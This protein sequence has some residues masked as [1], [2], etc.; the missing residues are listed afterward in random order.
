MSSSFFVLVETASGYA[1]FQTTDGTEEIGSLLPTVQSSVT[2]YQLFSDILKLKS[3]QPF[4]SAENALENIMRVS[5]NAVSE[6]LETFLASNLPSTKKMKKHNQYLGVQSASL[7]G[8]ISEKL[9]VPC[10]T[11]EVVS[12]LIR[13]VRLHL[14][15]YISKIASGAKGSDTQLG[16]SG[17]LVKKARLG[18]GHSYSRTKVK[19]NINKQD[20]MII[21]SIALLDQLD[22]DLNTCAMRVKEWYSWHFPE[23]QKLVPDS[24][25]FARLV[26]VIGKRNC[27]F[28]ND[29]GDML[30]LLTKS[31]L[32]ETLSKE[33]I[34]A[35]KSSMGFEISDIDLINLTEFSERVVAL[36]K[37]RLELHAYLFKKVTLVAPNLANLVGE[38][39]AARLISHA[40]SLTSL[41]KCPASTIQILGAEKALFRA[42][43]TRSNTPKYGLLF[44]SSF[45]GKAQQKNKGRISRYLANKCALASR[46][47]CFTDIDAELLSSH[48][49]SGKNG[50][51]E[52][53]EIGKLVGLYG[54]KMREQVEDRLRFFETG[55][56]PRKNITVMKEVS[57][58][59]RKSIGV[60]DS[61]SEESE[62]SKK[63][64]KSK[65]KKRK[66]EE[67]EEEENEDSEVDGGKEKKKRKKE[68]KEKKAKK[69]KKKKK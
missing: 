7:A 69:V 40:G 47:D 8:S 3:F 31:T 2:D 24:L 23:L 48:A 58:T 52:Q 5:E 36:G 19:F 66:K 61:Q 49:S 33:I 25:M 12:E 15:K 28:I 42:L 41:A 65:G 60:S 63:K 53:S 56:K 4:S 21:Q 14:D 1:L 10:Q 22:K 43:K 59:I 30:E 27:L 46:I 51:L 26:K 18:L 67:S 44:H 29:A 13:G 38:V 16:A 62:D 50:A 55:E 54:E 17:D 11:V 9:S 35:A 37:Y 45:I 68:K 34:S 64:S 32:D 20:N 39:I 6:D 57:D